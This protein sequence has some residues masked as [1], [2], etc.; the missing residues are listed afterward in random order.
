MATTTSVL[1]NFVGGEPVESLADEADPVLNPSTGEE[2]A[3]APRSTAEDVDGAVMAARAA[4]PGWS[5]TTPAERSLALLRLADAIERDADDLAALE[6]A[7]AGKPI[8]TMRAH[9][10]GFIVDNLRFFAGAVR[11]LGG[12]TAGEYVSG[13][14]SIV[15]REPVG[16]IGQISP[17]NYPLA[18][19]IWKIG[20]A[21]GTG[22][23]VVLK[24]A[25][26]T[27]MTAV[28]LAELAADI[29]PP[30]VLNVVMGRGNVVGRA[31]STHPEV[32]MVAIT[33]STR[34]GKAVMAAGAETVKRTH[35]ELGGNAPVLVF[36]D[37]DVESTAAK[38]AFAGC[39]NCG[40]DCTAA[41]R[42][43]VAAEIHD[44][45]VDALSSQLRGLRVGDALAE[46]TAVGPLSSARQLDRVNGLIG[47]LP[48]HAEVVT[49]GTRPDRAGFFLEPGVVAALR[50]DDE[51]VQQETFGPM[52]TVQSFPG[53]QQ[54]VEWANQTPYGLASSVWT[55]DVARALRVANALRFGAVWVNNHGSLTPEM[56]HGGYKQSGHGKDMSVL[57][58][59]EY[60]EIKH[61]MVDSA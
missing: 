6:S 33:G 54:A 50:Q 49:G 19:A 43:L 3:L 8:A 13:L 59:D 34:T 25:E 16:V 40:Q 2:I 47:R 32:D 44:E 52:I 12:P 14:T 51:M 60:T 11:C 37:V 38:I 29:L 31:L 53:E 41:A 57:A 27:P 20:P 5:T 7:N 55:T 23:T 42:V 24:P 28:R 58:V 17:W 22:N 61:V 15:R 21:L 26:T 46:D 36:E 30:G 1:R 35:L 10:L 9:E 48:D 39:Y 45:L 56:P 4:F 18:N